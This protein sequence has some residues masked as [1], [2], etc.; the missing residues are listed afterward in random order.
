MEVDLVQGFETGPRFGNPGKTTVLPR[1]PWNKVTLIPST[2][3]CTWY[4]G[5]GYLVPSFATDFSSYTVFVH[6]YADFIHYTCISLGNLINR[7][8]LGF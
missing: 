6:F 7:R 3:E 4:Q 8:N 5:K 1:L 2:K